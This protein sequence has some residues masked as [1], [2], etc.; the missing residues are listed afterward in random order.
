M[1]IATGRRRLAPTPPTVDVVAYPDLPPPALPAS[2]EAWQNAVAAVSVE[3]ASGRA[4]NQQGLVVSDGAVLTVLDLTEEIAS[5]SVKVS[6]RDTYPAEL[7][8]LDPR[9]GASL[10]SVDAEGLAVAPGEGATIAPG[11]PVLLLSRD[12]DGELVVEE[13]YASPSLNAPDICS[14]C[15]SATGPTSNEGR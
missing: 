15:S 7:E 6:G 1:T 8:R 9:T 2:V 3:L 13:T 14:R 12:Q 4:R 11:E 10:L 5:L